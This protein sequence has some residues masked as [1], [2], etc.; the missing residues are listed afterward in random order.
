MPGGAVMLPEGWSS[1]NPAVICLGLA[2]QD[3]IWTMDALPSRAGKHRASRFDSTGGGMAATAAVAIAKLGGQARFWGRAGQDAAG[4]AMR[5]E[6]ALGGVDVEQFRLFPGARSSVSGI[7]VDGAGE[8]LIVNF[9]GGNL[10]VEPDW[11]PADT[12]NAG[13]VLAD[14]RWTEGA[15]HLFTIARAYG[16]PTILDADV[17]DRQVFHKLLPLADHAIFSEQALEEFAGGRLDIVAEH[18]CKIAA[19]TRGDKGVE[20]LENGQRRHRPAF[21]VKVVDTTG[22]GDVFHG[23]WA[24]AIAAGADAAQ[25]AGFASAAAALK[26]TR[27]GGRAG[28]P[29]FNDTVA[30]WR[31]TT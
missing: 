7:M 29:N 10:P 14:P 6:L 13:A 12:G 31:S 18:G 16:I 17:A 1:R 5:R 20:W 30:L 28:I 3:H 25:A 24:M 9:R 8:R 4:D 23:A 22:A 11:L 26:C 19:V 2:A 21:H 27:P 15:I